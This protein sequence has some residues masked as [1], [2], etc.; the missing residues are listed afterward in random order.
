MNRPS[1]NN[2]PH[3][4]IFNSSDFGYDVSSGNLTGRPIKILGRNTDVDDVR[5]DL[6]EL[7]GTY[8]FPPS[9]GIQISLSSTNINDNPT[10]SGVR[11]IEIRYLDNNYVERDLL[12]P[13][14]GTNNVTSSITN[15]LRINGIHAT[16]IGSSGSAIGNIDIKNIGGTITYARI[17][18]GLNIFFN[19]IYTVPTGSHYYAFGWDVGSGT[20]AGGRWTEFLLRATAYDGTGIIEYKENIFHVWDIKVIQDTSF[21]KPFKFPIKFPEKTDIK[22]SVISDSGTANASCAGMIE[23]ILVSY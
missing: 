20:P 22:I 6:W 14:N 16:E 9:G 5:E 18:I 7:G 17:P 11:Q 21:Y 23:G 13:T 4:N 1:L 12:L 19:A 8:V 3:V 2:F 15:L 10:G